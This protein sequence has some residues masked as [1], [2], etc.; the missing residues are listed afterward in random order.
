MIG[1]LILRNAMHRPVRTAITMIAVAIEVMLVIIVVGLTSGLILNPP[2]APRESA[3][4]SWCSRLR[5]RFSWRSAAHDADQHR[6]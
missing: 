1:H 5:R 2:S 4:I 6:Q 3:R